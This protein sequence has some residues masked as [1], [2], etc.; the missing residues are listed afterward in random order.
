MGTGDQGVVLMLLTESIGDGTKGRLAVQ[1]IETAAKRERTET[2][3][4][5]RSGSYSRSL[6]TGSGR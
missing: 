6:I 1:P 2:R 5:Y 3:L 4:A